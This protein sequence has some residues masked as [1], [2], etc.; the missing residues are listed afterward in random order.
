MKRRLLCLLLSAILLLPLLSSC[1][2]ELSTPIE[3]ADIYTL[4]T[5]ADATP[6]AVRAVELAIN[7]TLYFRIGYIVD[8]VA[9]SA[10]EY[11]DVINK[12]FEVMAEL[13]AEKKSKKSKKNTSSTE[14]VPDEEILTGEKIISMLENGEDIPSTEPSFDIFLIRSYDEYFKLAAEEKLSAVTETLS[15]EAKLLKNYI[16]GT[17]FSAATINKKIYGVPIND[18][19]GEY[20]FIVFD[21]ELLEKYNYDA[22]TMVTLEDLENY[23]ALIKE[24]EPDVIPLKE[25]TDS[26]DFDFMFGDGFA[27]YVMES[28]KVGSTYKN[29][30]LL[31]Y[32]GM[33]ARYRSLGYFENGSGSNDGRFAVSFLTGNDNDVYN[34]EK[35]TGYKYEYNIFKK[36][37][38]TNE[39]TIKSIYGVSKYCTA[40]DITK[41]MEVLA[42]LFTD[43]DYQDILTYG[44]ENVNYKLD[45]NGQVERLNSDYIINPDYT[46]NKFL[47]HTLAGDDPEKWEKAKAQNFASTPSKVL[48]YDFIPTDFEYTD[49]EENTQIIFEPDYIQIMRDIIDEYYPSIIKGTIVDFDIEALTTEANDSIYAEMKDE[50][51]LEFGKQ[52]QLD[53]RSVIEKSIGT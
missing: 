25:A 21:A 51:E 8:I 30:K 48:G 9:V 44:I 27:T 35:E 11:D 6:E 31:A 19:I 41:A 10:E 45:D 20:K 40:N 46:G 14:A 34:L 13:E 36:P 23:L 1:Q 50:L 49:S 3:P 32:Y 24:N 52:I 47:T 22:K 53:Y 18:T 39:N 38:A 4:Y 17:F 7:R 29:E 15:N 33:I 43:P 28:G 5:I 37:S 2:K 26:A 16:H 42:A 12:Q